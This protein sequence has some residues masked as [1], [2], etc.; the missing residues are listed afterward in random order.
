LYF[1]GK[2]KKM[3]RVTLVFLVIFSLSLTSCVITENVSFN[4]DNSGKINYKFDMTKVMQMMGGKM[5]QS[6]DKKTKDID[7][8]FTMASLYEAKK[9]S[10]AKLSKEEQEKFKKMEKF[11]CHMVM[12]EK[13]GVFVYE[14]TADFKNTAEL[15]EMMSPVNTLS[16][17]SP[18]GK[19]VPAD[20]APK[21]DGIT[22]YTFDGKKFSKSVV[23]K[24]KEETKEDLKKG[25][26]KEGVEKEEAEAFSN[27]MSQS[28]DM[29]MGE[30]TYD[31]VVTFPKKVK[32]VSIA[33]AKIS[34][35][36]KTVTV[37]YP[38]KDYMESKNL[39][40]EVEL[41]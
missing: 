41:E 39:N 13:E 15:Q 33:N 6:E 37:S 22:R 18:K 11:A 30:S 8:T 32:K 36:K 21:N 23:V 31:M 10:I 14:M 24:S 25:L 27:Q 9:D 38:M 4:A 17:L 16:E 40:F 2:L 19:N 34:E 7:S 5:G 26:Q 1:W 28:M 29:M 35:D 3:K 20:A 12:K